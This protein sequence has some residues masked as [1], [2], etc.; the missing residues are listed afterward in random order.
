MAEMPGAAAALRV[1]AEEKLVEDAPAATAYLHFCLNSRPQVEKELVPQEV[2]HCKHA[3]HE[4]DNP[5]FLLV[6]A[7]LIDLV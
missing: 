5:R 1:E 7:E 2:P 6:V 3:A 4:A